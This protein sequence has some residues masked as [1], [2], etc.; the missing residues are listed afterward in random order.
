M[1]RMNIYDMNFKGIL[2]YLLKRFLLLIAKLTGMKGVCL[3]LGTGLFL[4]EKISSA[5]FASIIGIVLCNA[6]G[7]HIVDSCRKLTE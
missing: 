3:C 7:Q 1:K 2:V 6:S 4:K 5:V